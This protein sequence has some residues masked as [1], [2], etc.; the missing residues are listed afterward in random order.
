M[1][2]VD[3][4]SPDTIPLIMLKIKHTYGNFHRPNYKKLIGELATDED[5]ED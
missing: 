5:E 3:T 2:T 4:P 1:A